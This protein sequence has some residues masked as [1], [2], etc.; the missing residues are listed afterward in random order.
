MS[1]IVLIISL[2]T[3]SHAAARMSP[4]SPLTARPHGCRLH[5]LA[6]RAIHEGAFTEAEQL[7]D[8]ALVESDARARTFFLKALLYE[9]MGQWEAARCTFR[10]G[11]RAHP[12]DGTLLQ[13][14]GLMESRVGDVRLALRLLRQCVA[15]DGTLAPVLRWQRFAASVATDRAVR[16]VAA[17]CP[18]SSTSACDVEST[19]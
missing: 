11:N 16:G 18:A 2:L 9:R 7:Y 13:G 10:D 4:S 17:A 8:R 19:Q 14:W 15:C 6:N 1:T 5:A 3:C 12:T